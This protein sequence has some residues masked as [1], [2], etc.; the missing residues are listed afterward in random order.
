MS[1]KQS[2]FWLFLFCFNDCRWSILDC[3]VWRRCNEVKC[4]SFFLS[5]GKQGVRS[6]PKFETI[7]LF[8]AWAS[9]EDFVRFMC[10]FKGEKWRLHMQNEIMWSWIL[11]P[12]WVL[13]LLDWNDLLEV[14]HVKFAEM[15]FFCPNFAELIFI[16]S[17]TRLQYLFW[18]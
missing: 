16:D 14:K 5:K 13:M 2:A 3:Y 1:E 4:F 7:L 12:Y 15:S 18:L 6:L 17:C 11:T 8:K 10:H 9:Y